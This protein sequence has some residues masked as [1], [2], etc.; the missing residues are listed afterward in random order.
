MCA[1]RQWSGARPNTKHSSPQLSKTAESARDVNRIHE[2]DRLRNSA[3]NEAG[4][5]MHSVL[6][7]DINTNLRCARQFVAKSASD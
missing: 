1:R 6:K 4:Q 3:T 7:H 5:K 2:A